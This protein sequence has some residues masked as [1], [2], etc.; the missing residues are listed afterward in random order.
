MVTM[1]RRAIADTNI[2]KPT[3]GLAAARMNTT[4][5][6]RNAAAGMSTTMNMKNTAARMNTIMNMRNAAAAAITT[7]SMRNAAVGMSTTMNMK[8]AAARMSTTMN[9]RNAAAITTMSMMNVIADMR[10]TGIMGIQTRTGIT[11]RNMGAEMQRSGCTSLRIW[12][13]PTA[14]RRWSSAS[15]LWTA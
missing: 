4:M 3:T 14:R 6:M 2:T 5:N 9:M 8:N 15:P 1:R 7:M 11:V 12:A 10:A 13:V